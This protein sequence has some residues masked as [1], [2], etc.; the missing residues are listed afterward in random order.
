MYLYEIKTRLITSKMLG[1]SMVTLG[2]FTEA[3]CVFIQHI[4]IIV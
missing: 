3:R 2:N 1:A 4:S